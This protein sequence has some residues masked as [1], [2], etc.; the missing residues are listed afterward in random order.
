MSPTLDD[1]D[2]V[3]EEDKPYEE[4]LLAADTGTITF[5]DYG[6]GNVWLGLR[7]GNEPDSPPKVFVRLTLRQQKMLSGLFIDCR[8]F[9]L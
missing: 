2:A 9:L 8:K 6:N 5:R 7:E 3:L 1:S 4:T